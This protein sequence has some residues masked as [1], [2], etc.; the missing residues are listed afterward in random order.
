VSDIKVDLDYR[1]AYGHRAWR[2]VSIC[3]LAYFIYT[4]RFPSLWSVLRFFLLQVLHRLR[5]AQLVEEFDAKI[6][7]KVMLM[8]PHIYSYFKLLFM[9]SF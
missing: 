3:I 6:D 8:F 7:D 1:M 2:N 4:F 5:D 9:P